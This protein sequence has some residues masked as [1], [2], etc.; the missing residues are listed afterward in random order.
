LTIVIAYNIIY[1]FTVTPGLYAIRKRHGDYE[2][3]QSC[4]PCWNTQPWPIYRGLVTG[5][6]SITLT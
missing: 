4:E 1:F 5:Q 3:W 2:T 6:M